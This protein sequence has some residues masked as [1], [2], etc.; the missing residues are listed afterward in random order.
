M[1]AE[2]DSSHRPGRRPGKSVGE[3]AGRR[4]EPNNANLCPL[5]SALWPHF[6][7]QNFSFPLPSDLSRSR[8]EEAS[9]L[10][11]SSVGGRRCRLGPTF[12]PSQRASDASGTGRVGRLVAGHGDAWLSTVRRLREINCLPNQFLFAV[13]YPPAG[14]KHYAVAQQIC[15]EL[16]QS[17]TSIIE[18]GNTEQIADF[19][20]C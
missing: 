18:I 10:D 11:L 15:R 17:Q 19:A 5:P 6:C 2:A 13:Q 16:Q 4:N 8:R 20:R 1:N 12:P 9:I 3:G 14:G 7:F